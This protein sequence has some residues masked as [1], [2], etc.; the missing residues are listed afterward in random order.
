MPPNHSDSVEVKIARIETSTTN[1]E[2]EIKELKL[3][4]VTRA[5]FVPVRMAVYGLIGFICI[6]LLGLVI[7][8]SV[9]KPEKQP[10]HGV[11][12]AP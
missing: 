7:N 10:P 8:N 6:T 12:L 1:I 3:N 11:T 5:E 2:R 4:Y 9:A